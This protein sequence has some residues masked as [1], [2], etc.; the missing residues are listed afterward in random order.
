MHLLSEEQKTTVLGAI[1]L[2]SSAVKSG[3]SWTLQC[4]ETYEKALGCFPLRPLPGPGEV[5]RIWESF[6]APTLVQEN[7][8]RLDLLKGELHDFYYLMQS[9]EQ[10]IRHATGREMALNTSVESIK[11]AIDE[12][13]PF[14]RI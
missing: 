5:D 9:F 13:R 7:Q 10:I 8:I 1:G 6:W 11:K 2:F 14:R 4:Q 12:Y 3:E